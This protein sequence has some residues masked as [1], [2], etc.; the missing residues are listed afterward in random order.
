MYFTGQSKKSFNLIFLV[1]AILI[2]LA[3]RVSAHGYMVT[4]PIRL[5]PNGDKISLAGDPTEVFPCGIAG[6][7]PGPVTKYRPGESMLVAYNITIP[8]PGPCE[9][10]LSMNGDNNFT[11]IAN[12]GECGNT[13]GFFATF[14]DLPYENCETCTV[15]F[16]WNGGPGQLYLN[17]ANIQ[18]S[19]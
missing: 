15:R 12:L 6:N 2:G 3:A 18:I 13:L 19:L 10:D 5:V 4:P 16:Y 11:N 8:H 1:F 14:V 7:S 9:I 17:C